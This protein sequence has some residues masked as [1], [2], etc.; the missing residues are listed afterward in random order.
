QPP[1]FEHASPR[2]GEAPTL[3]QAVLLG[4]HKETLLVLEGSQAPE[5]MTHAGDWSVW[6]TV[7][8]EVQ[9]IAAVTSEAFQQGK[10]V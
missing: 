8:E 7:H 6:V 1:A 9:R 4:D 2:V 10:P 5:S 3:P